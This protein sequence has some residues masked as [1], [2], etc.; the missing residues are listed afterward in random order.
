[1]TIEETVE[2]VAKAENWNARIAA[3][4][5]IP[6]QFGT[7]SHQEIYS[8][9]ARTVY[10]PS[11]A[12]DFAYIH[13]HDDYELPLAQKTYDSA[14]A[15]TNGFTEVSYDALVRTLQTEPTTLRVFRLLLGFTA[16]EFAAATALVVAVDE[17][18]LTTGRIRSIESGSATKTSRA[19]ERCA[20]VIDSTMTKKLFGELPKGDGR[21]KTDKPDTIQGWATVLQYASGGVPLSVFLHQRQYGGAFRQ[22][23]DATSSKRGGIIED[24]VDE[25]FVQNQVPFIRTG[26]HS[27][28]LSLTF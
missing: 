2:A 7:A 26:S 11:L 17:K 19:L 16:Q 15:L 8:A 3:I 10:V 9:I 25:V 13:W 18:P 20:A 23:L 12:P 5:L 27:R 24:A 22:L 21:L 1:M 28:R 14:Y 6:E 4:R